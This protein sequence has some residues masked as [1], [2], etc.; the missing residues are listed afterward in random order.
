MEQARKIT[1]EEHRDRMQRRRPWLNT[2]M[3]WY[4]A[5]RANISAHHPDDDLSLMTHRPNHAMRGLG[6]RAIY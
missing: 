3:Q 1:D 6:K 4:T 2:K 5:I